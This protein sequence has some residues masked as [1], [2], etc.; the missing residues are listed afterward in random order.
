[1]Q[2][3]NTEHGKGSF[4]DQVIAR[5]GVL[6][7][8]FCTAQSAP[9]LIEQLWSFAKAG[10]LDN[11]L[12]SVFKE[13]LFVHLSRFCEVRYCIVRHVGFLVGHGRPAGDAAVIPNTVGEALELL[14][15]PVPDAAELEACLARLESRS[16]PTEIP[17]AGTVLES[18]LF[19]ALTVIFIEPR[20]AGRV[21]RAITSAFGDPRYEL[22]IAF[23]A[24]VRTA[25]YWT[26][27]HPELAYEPDMLELMATHA[28]LAQLM[29]DPAEAQRAKSGEALRRALVD[30]S[31]TGAALRA[32]EERF[33]ALV[34][35]SAHA[36]YSMSP[37]WSEMRVLDG[38]GFIVDTESPRQDWLS[39]YIAA[40]DQPKVLAAI[41]RAIQTKSVFE[42][43]HRVRLLDGT[44][45]WTLSRAVPLLDE[46]GDIVEWFGAASDVT[47]RN[48][49][50]EALR[51][52]DRRKDEFLA[53]LAHELRNPLSPLSNSLEIAVT[54][55]PRDNAP[56]QGAIQ[57]M[58]RQLRHLVRLVDDLMDVG[59]ISAG[60]IRLRRQ[61]VTVREVLERSVEASQAVIDK[62]G[63]TLVI[64]HDAEDLAIVGDLDRLTQVF[65]NLLSNAAKY[66]E[67]GGRIEVQVRHEAREAV[68][69]V[70]DTGIGIPPDAMSGLFKLFSQVRVHA[71]H[72]EGG[73][74]IGLS[75]VRKLVEMHGGTVS[76]VSQG[77]GHGST[78][79][80][81][82][83]LS[84]EAEGLD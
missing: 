36:V 50:E 7:N 58:R 12:P 83:P 15:R 61:R 25:H 67:R 21:R 30:L 41:H 56:L 4:R 32:T 65:S 42:L 40:E 82:L 5:F 17:S 34:N 54:T 77:T 37:D 53:T 57:V 19:D 69:S 39:E 28:E 66:T 46:K 23:L 38:R 63:H 49:A 18:D 52:S 26:E 1:M 55:S 75:L 73:L 11:P 84:K 35:A 72:A 33:R 29:L 78:F 64:H 22:L 59:R 31:R 43:E 6:P 48:Q 80:V 45:G 47:A 76:A 27:T 2:E 10:Y 51:A 71:H 16:T 62:Q 79:T 68:V 9:G 8:F 24:F 44:L 74:G 70:V 14:K 81:R 13:R 60:K 3:A 20:H